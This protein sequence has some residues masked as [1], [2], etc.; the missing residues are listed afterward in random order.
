MLG[1]SVNIEYINRLLNAI[2][3]VGYYQV[4]FINGDNTDLRKQNIS[5]IS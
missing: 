2:Y 4:V 3:G 1:K 5:I